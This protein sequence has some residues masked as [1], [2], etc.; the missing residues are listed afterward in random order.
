MKPLSQYWRRRGPLRTVVFGTVV[1]LTALVAVPNLGS[2]HRALVSPTTSVPSTTTTIGLSTVTT[3]ASPTPVPHAL[4]LPWPS[5]ASA[6]VAVPRLS[7]AATSAQQ[8][9]VP[10]ASIT[11]LMTAWVVLQKLPLALNQ[12]GPCLQVSANDVALYDHDVATDQSSVKVALGET[13]CEGM[14][15]RGMLVHSAGNFAQLLIELAHMSDAQFVNEMN[16]TALSF[17]LKHTHYVDYSG[18]SAG[19]VSTAQEQ[20]V[21]AVNLMTNE[22][23]VRQIVA[24]PAVKLPVAGTVASYTPYEGQYGVVGVKSGYT[25]PAGGCDVMAI[26]V[27]IDHTVIPIYAVVIG[28][29]GANAINRSGFIGLQLLDM[30]RSRIRVKST[31]T[32]R[33]VEWVGWPGYVTTTT[34]TTAPTTTTTGPSPSTTSSTT[35]SSTTTTVH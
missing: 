30:I 4:R 3:V 18:I 35:T 11:K 33:V 15:L 5:I 19:D 28:V 7:I 29:H 24:L 1:T 22:P 21:V 17:G 27:F 12:R 23:V 31:A 34:T 8:P 14:L 13:L 32:G 10:I 16:K 26:N 25:I 9:V 20:S 6:A 2:S